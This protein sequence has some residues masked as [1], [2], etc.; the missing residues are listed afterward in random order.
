MANQL[1]ASWHP[2]FVTLLKVRG[3]NSPWDFCIKNCL[4][5][6]TIYKPM[7]GREPLSIRKVCLI[8]RALGMSGKSFAAII[9]YDPFAVVEARLD[10][11]NAAE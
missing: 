4:D 6:P 9:E 1:S 3:Y 7:T 8:A 11:E 10:S 5:W 2:N